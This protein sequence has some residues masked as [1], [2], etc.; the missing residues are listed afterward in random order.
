MHLRFFR[1]CA[2]TESP[3]SAAGWLSTLSECGFLE[4]QGFGLS[5]CATA[6]YSSG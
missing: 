1:N 6:A 4:Q 3:W 5:S 2:Q